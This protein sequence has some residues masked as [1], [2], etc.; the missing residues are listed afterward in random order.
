MF[1]NIFQQTKN[2]KIGNNSFPEQFFHIIFLPLASSR[3]ACLQ[4]CVC[5]PA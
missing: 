5:L 3:Q 1:E 2:I 4:K